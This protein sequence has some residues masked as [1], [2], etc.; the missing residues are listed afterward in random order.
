[1][2]EGDDN[3][4]G[5]EGGDREP[6]DE[7]DDPSESA[8]AAGAAVGDPTVEEPALIES[9]RPGR[10][11]AASVPAAVLGAVTG[12]AV[13]A[14]L[15]ATGHLA[16]TVRFGEA[17]AGDAFV[18]AWSKSRS[19]SFVVDSS[20]QRQLDDGSTLDAAELLVQAPGR[21]IVRQFGGI[22]GEIDGRS[23]DCY[24]APGSGFQCIPGQ[25]TLQ[26]FD[27]EVAAEAG[28]VRDAIRAPGGP[29]YRVRTDDHGCYELTQTRAY[30]DPTFGRNATLCFDEDSGALRSSE[31]HFDDVVERIRAVS[32]R[33]QI[34]PSDFDLT[35]D[36]DFDT[37]DEQ[38]PLGSYTVGR[39]N[40]SSS[41]SSTPPGSATST[42]PP[43]AGDP[44]APGPTFR[45]GQCSDQGLLADCVQ[46]GGDI[47]S[48]AEAFTRRL[49]Y[50]DASIR[51]T[52]CGRQYAL[53][54]L[55]HGAAPK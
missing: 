24:T 49:S 30:P 12:A 2:S 1:M 15:V 36:E 48:V 51:D 39:D 23:I 33:T 55:R 13:V 10:P 8:G 34:Q 40:P 37:P 29:R 27:E 4:Q 45:A 35:V 3:D 50:N 11:W 32:I 42:R 16:S 14:I 19:G 5:D 26:S 41:T 47:V 6:A 43:A 21:R 7:R 25:P 9:R 31:R 38:G 28:D 20:W 54:G 22:T 52:D 53:Y 18:Q 44:C 46:N 17:D